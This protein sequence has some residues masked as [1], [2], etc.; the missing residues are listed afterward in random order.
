MSGMDSSTPGGLRRTWILVAVAAAVAA[1]VLGT[2]VVSRGATGDA[3]AV[4]AG[5]PSPSPTAED[6]GAASTAGSAAPGESSKAAAAV[7]TTSK[8]VAKVE[9]F[10]DLPVDENVVSRELVEDAVCSM[11]SDSVEVL[12]GTRPDKSPDFDTL[13]DAAITLSDQIEFWRQSE[14]LDPRINAAIRHADRTLIHW[15]KA[16]GYRDAGEKAKAN[17]ELALAD[18][19]LAEIDR[20]AATELCPTDE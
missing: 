13:R 2:V 5:S 20:A 11:T 7:A 16:V 3:P 17:D 10:D 12:V 18:K 1:V 15:R 4:A 14:N 6:G 8:K 9:S 19:D